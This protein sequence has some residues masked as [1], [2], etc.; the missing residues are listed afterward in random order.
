MV[1][2]ETQ[3]LEKLALFFQVLY[4]ASFEEVQIFMPSYIILGWLC[5]EISKFI[6]I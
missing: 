5:P 6:M 4:C 1:I 3:V 2:E